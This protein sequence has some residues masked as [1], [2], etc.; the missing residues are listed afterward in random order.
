MR[1]YFL[2]HAIAQDRTPGL[3]DA[4]RQLIPEGIRKTEQLALQLNAYNVT[5]TIIYTSPLARALQTAEIIAAH[6]EVPVQATELLAPGFNS[7][8][9]QMLVDQHKFDED[10]LLVGHEPDFSQTISQ[11]IGGGNI[12]VK[13]GGLARVDVLNQHPLHGTLVWLL[14]PKVT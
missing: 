14:S 13:K 5:P 12:T 8:A 9:L 6:I 2:R 1:L 10:L 7:R 3:S 4:D 11:I